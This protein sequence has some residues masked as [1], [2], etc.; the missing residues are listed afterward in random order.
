MR[1]RSLAREGSETAV[2]WQWVAVSYV[3]YLAAVSWT[4]PEFKN[5]RRPLLMAAAL[6]CGS[7]AIGLASG[8]SGALPPSLEVVLPAL[9][10]LVGYRLSGLLFV[11]PNPRIE[12]WL[13]SVDDAL[14]ARPGVLAWFR[15]APR[16]VVEYFEL[17]YLLV[18]L[19]VPAGAATLA[20]GGNAE[21]VG[22]FWTIV[23]LAEFACYGMLPWIQT[24]PP[25]V[26][27][28][29]TSTTRRSQLV[30]PLNLGIVD[31]ASIRANTVPSGHAAGAL[32]TALAVGSTM[33]TAGAVFLIFAVSIAV[34]AVLGR[35]HYVVDSVLGVL[36]AVVAWAVV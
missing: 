5:A 29:A 23:L 1:N 26:V 22:R 33:P 9:V 2:R 25:R 30:R 28:A 14:L 36:V 10:L 34:A 21:Q 18:Y 12:R 11:E 3:S 19:V 8:M 15:Q 24:R 31:R 20:L 16:V 6:A 32:A 13:V 4:K 35:Y 27:E 7:L 17:S